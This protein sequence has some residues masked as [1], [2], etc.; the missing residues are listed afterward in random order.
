MG[1]I[2]GDDVTI[3]EALWEDL[4]PKV[5][6]EVRELLAGRE[7]STA[8]GDSENSVSYATAAHEL[9]VS[10]STLSSWK[11]SGKIGSYGEGK[12]VGVKISE[13]RALLNRPRKP[14]EDTE[15]RAKNA[16]EKIR[17]KRPTKE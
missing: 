15:T 10:V 7:S 9:G 13:C 12:T 4:R 6:E 5:R 16:L 3:T 2:K 17:R 14:T 1:C 8:A 11:R